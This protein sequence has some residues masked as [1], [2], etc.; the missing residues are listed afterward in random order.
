MT[1]KVRVLFV[2]LLM[3]KLGQFRT[4]EDYEKDGKPAICHQENDTGKWLKYDEANIT[5]SNGYIEKM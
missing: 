4:R 3:K 5:N 1:Q 2:V